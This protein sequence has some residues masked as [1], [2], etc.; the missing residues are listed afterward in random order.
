M[1][2]LVCCSVKVFI[3]TGCPFWGWEQVEDSV[4][5]P[6]SGGASEEI[7]DLCELGCGET[8]PRAEESEERI[9]R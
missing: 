1:R 2:A 3:R 9:V 8:V 6:S 5:W 4:A 7:E